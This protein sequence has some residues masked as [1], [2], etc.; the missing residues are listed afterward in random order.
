MTAANHCWSQDAPA[1]ARTTTKH[2]ASDTASEFD[3]HLHGQELNICETASVGSPQVK[4]RSST[5][6]NTAAYSGPASAYGI[7]ARTED[8]CSR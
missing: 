1:A 6:G 3:P 5:F 8:R 2:R 7:I 4:E